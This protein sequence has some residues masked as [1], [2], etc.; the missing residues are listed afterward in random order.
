VSLFGNPD[1]LREVP[2]SAKRRKKSGGFAAGSRALRAVGLVLIESA[3]VGKVCRKISERF[4]A[5]TCAPS[6]IWYR[7]RRPK[8]EPFMLLEN[9]E[10]ELPA[11]AAVMD[12]LRQQAKV[13]ER[14]R[15]DRNPFLRCLAVETRTRTT[16]ELLESE[17][18]YN[19]AGEQVETRHYLTKQVDRAEFVKVLSRSYRDLFDLGKAGLRMFWYLVEAIQRAPGKPEIY[20]YWRSVVEF[21]GEVKSGEGKGTSK[22]S[23]SAFYDGLKQLENAGFIARQDRPHW[24][25]LNPR[26]LWNGSRV[27]FIN[28]LTMAQVEHMADDEK[29]RVVKPEA[30]KPRSRRVRA[31]PSTLRAI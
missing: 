4:P 8:P 19:D 28:M 3:I 16:G 30:K 21:K 7:L 1:N 14:A 24:F 2:T 5:G 20:L 27:A 11:L 25:W 6:E 29:P 17:A 31:K 15:L 26:R 13:A 22:I 18:V 12:G 9:A 23:K 10:T